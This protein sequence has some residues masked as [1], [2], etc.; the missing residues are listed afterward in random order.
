MKPTPPDRDP[1]L[2]RLLAMNAEDQRAAL[3]RMFGETSTA[4]PAIDV[5]QL[6]EASE[7]EE[8]RAILDL[9]RA[10]RIVDPL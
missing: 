2:R 8:R 9:L 5:R 10:Y 6:I 1:E 4:T 7:L 3:A